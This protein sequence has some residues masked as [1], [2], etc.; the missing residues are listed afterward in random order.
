MWMRTILL[1]GGLLAFFPVQAQ[2]GLDGPT[3]KVVDLFQEIARIPRCSGHE[4]GIGKWLQAWGVAHGFRTDSDG[5]GNVFI[6][7]PATPGY[8]SAPGLVLQTHMDM[9]C[10]KVEG[11]AHDFTRDAI[12]IVRD[13]EWLKAQG[14]T[15]G[16][17]DGIGMALALSIAEDKTL[18]HPRL[19]LVFTTGEETTGD[20]VE[21]LSREGID[22][23]VLLNLDSEQEGMLVIGDASATFSSIMVLL[24]SEALPEGSA[25]F[26]VAVGELRGGHSGVDILKRRANAIKVMARALEALRKLTDLRLVSVKGGTARN[27]IPRSVQ[28]RVAFLPAARE[29]AAQA[30]QELQEAIRKECGGE[31]PDLRITLASAEGPTTRTAFRTDETARL[32]SLLL[33]L[34]NG[35]AAMD[36]RFPWVPATSN[37]LGIIESHEGGVV[38]QSM[39]RGSDVDGLNGLTRKLAE[40]AAAS[41]ATARGGNAGSP[42]LT[43]P[44]SDVVKRCQGAYAR[45]F[46]KPPIVSVVHGG[47]E[48]GDISRKCP[49]LDILSLGPTLENAHSPTERVNLPSIK[50]LRDLLVAVLA[51]YH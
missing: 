1:C 40:V 2:A 35:V 4:G 28:A 49:G 41:G 45:L 8:E 33:A 9:V 13:G 42:W 5:G 46:G 15:L 32:I 6:R 26:S 23:K 24:Q 10:E 29:Q 51:E 27:A 50:K 44:D 38:I 34:P 37:S 18:A 3:Q 17:D 14:T 48:C 22:G 30:L 7:V 21:A 16:A 12:T 20:G 11:S 47:L 39:Q 19:E 36:A 43:S 31:D 25:L